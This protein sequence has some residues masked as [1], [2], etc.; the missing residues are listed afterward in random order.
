M[1]RIGKTGELMS[2]MG[3]QRTF[4]KKFDR[5]PLH[6]RKRTLASSRFWLGSMCQMAICCW[7]SGPRYCTE[8]AEV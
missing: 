8:G 2:L 1:R 7:G 3:Q 5:S 6:L 4:P